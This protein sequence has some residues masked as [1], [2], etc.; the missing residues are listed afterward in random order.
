MYMQP[1]T[2]SYCAT[3]ADIYQS[4]HEQHMRENTMIEDRSNVSVK[5]NKRAEKPVSVSGP[6]TQRMPGDKQMHI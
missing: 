3:M 5:I 6:L 2:V 1:T 4:K